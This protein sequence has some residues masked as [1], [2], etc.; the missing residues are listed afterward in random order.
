MSSEGPKWR[1]GNGGGGGGV[2]VD[3]EWLENEENRRPKVAVTAA[4][5][6]PILARLAANGRE[7]W[8]AR[9]PHSRRVCKGGGRNRLPRP[10]PD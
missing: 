3:L 5:A 2:W 8:S 4:F 1:G 7:I 6:G 9:S 10:K